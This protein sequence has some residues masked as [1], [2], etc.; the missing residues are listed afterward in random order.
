MEREMMNMKISFKCTW[1]SFAE[2]FVTNECYKI[3]MES[4]ISFMWKT[5]N[6]YIQNFVDA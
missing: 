4:Y 5:E 1:T 3:N 2:Q 6:K